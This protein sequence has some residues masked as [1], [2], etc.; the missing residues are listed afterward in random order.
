MAPDN[1]RAFIRRYIPLKQ[2]KKNRG[3]QTQG[4]HQFEKN[5]KRQTR[6]GLLDLYQDFAF[7]A[8]FI[9]ILN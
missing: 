9:E 4:E 8:Y 7:R 2:N 6:P 5:K 1:M 3:K